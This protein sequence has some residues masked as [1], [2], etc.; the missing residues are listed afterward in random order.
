MQTNLHGVHDLATVQR[1][2]RSKKQGRK[3]NEKAGRHLS[4]VFT[5]PRFPMQRA[6]VIPL[7]PPSSRK[8]IEQARV[9]VSSQY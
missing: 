9:R 3:P 1:H 2:K 4:I 5:N 6:Y 8:N 7:L